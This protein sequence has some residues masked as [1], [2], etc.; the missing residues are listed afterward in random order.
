MNHILEMVGKLK[1]IFTIILKI[2]YFDFIFSES[3]PNVKKAKI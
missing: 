3:G 2:E 1:M